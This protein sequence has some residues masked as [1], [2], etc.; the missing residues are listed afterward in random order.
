[1]TRK[2][3]L[4]ILREL[5]LKLDHYMQLTPGLLAN[6]FK[7]MGMLHSKNKTIRAFTKQ[8]ITTDKTPD[9]KIKLQKAIIEL[10]T[11]LEGVNK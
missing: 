7:E 9:G 6:W 2:N 8:F 3:S 11:K 5:N 4:G 1:M 10:I